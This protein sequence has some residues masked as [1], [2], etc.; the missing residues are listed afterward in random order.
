MLLFATNEHVTN[1]K[2]NVLAVAILKECDATPSFQTLYGS[3]EHNKSD[4]GPKDIARF[5]L[6][7][8]S[9]DNRNAGIVTDPGQL[10]TVMREGDAVH[11]PS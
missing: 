1:G 4:S 2:K 6:L 8:L 10:V 9:V 3:I 7:R 5:L 11:P